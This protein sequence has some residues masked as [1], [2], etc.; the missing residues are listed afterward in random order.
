MN[1]PVSD[2]VDNQIPQTVPQYIKYRSGIRHIFTADRCVYFA[3]SRWPVRCVPHGCFFNG[4][5]KMKRFLGLI[6]TA[7]LL[8]WGSAAHAQNFYAGLHGGTNY[9]T[10]SEMSWTGLTDD[11]ELE[12]D[13]GG[14]FGGKVGYRIPTSNGSLRAEFDITYRANTISDQTVNGLSFADFGINVSGDVISLAY[15]GNL[16]YEF[17]Q[18]KWKPYVGGGLGMAEVELK[19]YMIDD[20]VNP[21]LTAPDM[22]DTVWAAQFGAGVAYQIAPKFALT[23][24]YR[25]MFTE[26]PVFDGVE[27]S[28]LSH[29]FM[30]GLRFDF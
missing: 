5:S 16:W 10:N 7:G 24:D 6:C 1:F 12:Y 3:R 4:V 9:L 22:S 27:V 17:G 13:L 19:R 30:A 14:A 28:Y 21:P 23:L 29:T 8:A 11:V 20:G 25:L 2:A 15:M 26:A 18:S